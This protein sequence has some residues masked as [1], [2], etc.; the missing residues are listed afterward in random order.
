MN[1]N[2]CNLDRVVL[3]AVTLALPLFPRPAGAEVL[4][5]CQNPQADPN[6]RIPAC[7]ELIAGPHQGTGLAKIYIHR[8]AAWY[9]LGNFD[10]AIDDFTSALNLDPTSADA[11]KNRGLTYK[12]IGQSKEAFG[13]FTRALRL[14]PRSPELYN[15]RGAAYLDDRQY[16]AAIIDFTKAIGLNQDYTK[17]YINR[18]KAY[19]YTRKLD[20]AAADFSKVIALTPKDWLAYLNRASVLMDQGKLQDAIADCDQSIKLDPQNPAPYTMRGEL[21]RLQGNLQ[22]SLGDHNTSLS[23]KPTEEAYNNRA[24]TLMDQGKL[25]DAIADCNQ[26]IQL[27]P[28]FYLAYATLG[29]IEQKQQNFTA[30]L[31]DLNKAVSLDEKL[32]QALT[33]RGSTWL[34]L[35]NYN[36]ALNDFNKALQNQSDFAAAYAGRGQTYERQGD[37]EKAKADYQKALSYPPY[38]DAGLTMPAQ[39]LAKERLAALNEPKPAPQPPEVQA[40]VPGDIQVALHRG[41]ALLVGVADYAR[42]WPRLPSVANDLDNLE[43]KLKFHF[44]TVEKVPNPTVAQL[45]DRIRNFLIQEHNKFGERLLIYYSG[46]GFTDFNQSSQ[47]DDGYITGSDT[48]P[49]N[50][51][52]NKAV[53]NAVPFTDI[54]SWSRQSKA[55]YVLMAFDSCFSGSLFQTKAPAPQPKQYGFEVVRKYLTQSTRYFITAGSKNEEVAADSTFAQ[56]FLQGLEGDA[57]FFNQGI[58]SADAL[59]I[60]LGSQVASATKRVQT[61]QFRSIGN[62][63]QME[64]K[65]FFLTDGAAAGEITS[66]IASPGAAAKRK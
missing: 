36:N 48:P 53:A 9:R 50:L 45:R 40:A 7:T 19:Q 27:N 33:F 64:G 18:G 59:G 31:N 52:D 8:G 17:A 13:D 26:A 11:L 61:P 3:L 2:S 42:G 39:K 32:P 5:T 22:H 6:L 35:G 15:L 37:L 60:Y 20:S 4:Q 66:S 25:D 47:Q 10:Q 34:G 62:A 58:I 28:N 16:S 44:E 1:V 21:W 55:S 24:W 54:D 65:F 29:V 38:V 41:H 51:E 30:S 56:L 49:Y 14:Q 46:H 12:K 57:D 43:K 63:Y 23:L